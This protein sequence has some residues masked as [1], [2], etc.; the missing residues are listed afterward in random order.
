MYR[1]KAIQD[2]IRQLADKI[3]DWFVGLNLDDR[4]LVFPLGTEGGEGSAGQ[5][6][7]LSAKKAECF[8]IDKLSMTAPL[9]GRKQLVPLGLP[10][11][12]SRRGNKGWR[13]HLHIC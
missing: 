2:F 8:A 9:L 6:R 11:C 1:H 5:R 10:D 4:R 7:M 3:Q 13:G 12:I